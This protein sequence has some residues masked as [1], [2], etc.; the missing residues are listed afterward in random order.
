VNVL[1][2]TIDLLGALQKLES[3]AA[4]RVIVVCY[5]GQNPHYPSLMRTALG[6]Q[7]YQAAPGSALIEAT[8]FA[9]GRIPMKE[10]FLFEKVKR[11]FDLKK[12]TMEMCRDLPEDALPKACEILED[13]AIQENGAYVLRYD[14]RVT[15]LHW[16]PKLEDI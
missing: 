5:D 1:Y 11:F 7:S 6:M 2:R 12:A 13:W 10:Q 3:L 8:L 16:Q 14:Q 9:W 4:R 15:L